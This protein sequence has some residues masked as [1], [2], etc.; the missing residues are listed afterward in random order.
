MIIFLTTSEHTYTLERVREDTRSDVEIVPYE[1]VLS[2]RQLPVGTY[3][4]TDIDRLSLA[5][6]L[7]AA[8]LFRRINGADNLCKAINDPARVRSRYGLLRALYLHG[9][10]AFNV[11]RIDEGINPQRF[12][13]FI[14]F[15]SAHD[16]VL[17]DLLPDQAALDRAIE[18]HIANGTPEHAMLVI[19]YCA[20][21]IATGLYRK[22]SAYRIGSRVFAGESVHDDNWYVKTGRMG[23][24]QTEHYQQ[25]PEGEF[26]DFWRFTAPQDAATGSRIRPCRGRAGRLWTRH[27]R[28]QCRDPHLRPRHGFI[29][30]SL[31]R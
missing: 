7:S 14:R 23:V 31:I 9:Q 1:Q 24:A 19:E 5:M 3:V 17:S 18:Q 27:G 26:D 29:W 8:K 12:P 16:R 13:V 15:E 28:R 25:K 22:L 30:Q 4:F 2:A 6:Q 10:N 21:P 11:Y 20:E